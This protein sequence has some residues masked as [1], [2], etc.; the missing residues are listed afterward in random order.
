MTEL[1]ARLRRILNQGDDG[2]SLIESV[3]ALVIAGAV[4]LSL[5]AASMT[6]VRAT[7]N[8][9][10]NQQVGD[11]VSRAMEEARSMDYAALAMRSSDLSGDSYLSTCSG[12]PCFVAVPGQSAEPLVLNDQGSVFPH[13]STVSATQANDIDIT[14]YTYVTR[15]VDSFGADYKRVTVVARWSSYG[16]ERS[17]SD[18][19]IVT[20]TQRGLP[21]PIFTLQSVGVST[22]TVNP[23]ATVMY[24][25]RLTNQGARDRFSFTKNDTRTWSF[26]L[27]SNN[28]G[29]YTAGTDVAITD[30]NGDGII[31]SGLMEPTTSKTIFAIRTIPGTAIAGTES[32]TFTA[33]SVAQPDATT[34]TQS[35]AVVTT[36]VIGA[37]TATATPTPTTTTPTATATPTSTDCAAAA[38]PTPSAASGN[39]L[40]AYYLQG[41]AT[42]PLTMAR[43][44]GYTPPVAS[45]ATKTLAAGANQV[46][47]YAYTTRPTPAQSS[48]ATVSVWVST[49]ATSASLTA[50]LYTVNAAGNLSQTLG[51]VTLTQSPFSCAGYRQMVGSITVISSTARAPNNGAIRFKIENGGASAVTVAYD[52]SA[53]GSPTGRY[54]SNVVLGSD[55]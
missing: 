13:I 46:W 7:L 50:T 30:T 40:Y 42:N 10:V 38:I 34:A 35:V 31:D 18:S 27:D 49:A 14:L 41:G 51:S 25:M 19:T 43:A 6:A 17:R 39:N 8:G 5:G 20:E 44:P 9:R 36:I 28:S 15:P 52:A 1:R 23:G 26:Y 24:A 47:S 33:K 48:V 16:T 45:P 2:I 4:F 12:S 22:S 54:Q 21:L 53:S 55:L 37:I 11:F 29:T 3:V 32:T